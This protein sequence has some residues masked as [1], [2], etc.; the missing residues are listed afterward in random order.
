LSA[1]ARFMFGHERAGIHTTELPTRGRPPCL[2][3]ADGACTNEAP[4]GPKNA[5]VDTV[6]HEPENQ[7][8]AGA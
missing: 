2:G 4:P 1:T 5:S 8:S 7:M 3:A 6:L